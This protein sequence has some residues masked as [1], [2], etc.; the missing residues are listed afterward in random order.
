MVQYEPFDEGVEVNAQVIRSVVDA[1]PAALQSQGEQVLADHNI[2]EYDADQWFP[3][4]AYLDAYSEIAENMGERTINQIGN[5]IP[6]NAD[7]P[8]EVDTVVA[9][10][11]G[12][13]HVYNQNHRGGE[14]GEYAAEQIDDST[15]RVECENPYPCALDVGIIEGIADK[16]GARRAHVDEVGSDCRETGADACVYEVSW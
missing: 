15:V 3:Q 5:T 1:F 16:F 9:A 10:I 8:P 13:D 12:L 11:E 6:D 7:W 14:F 2:E 4:S